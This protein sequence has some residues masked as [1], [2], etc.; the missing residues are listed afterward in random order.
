[1]LLPRMQV[2]LRTNLI[3]RTAA[4]KNE[5]AK[6]EDLAEHVLTLVRAATTQANARV[7]CCVL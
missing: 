1:M 3:A 7:G 6:T 5:Q 2:S 4:L